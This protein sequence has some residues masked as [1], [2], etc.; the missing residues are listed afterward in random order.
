MALRQNNRSAKKYLKKISDISDIF[1]LFLWYTFF[2]GSFLVAVEQTDRQTD[3]KFLG[4][5]ILQK[6]ITSFFLYFS[7]KVGL[8]WTMFYIA[9][10]RPYTPLHRHYIALH[11][12]YT[13]LKR[14]YTQLARRGGQ[15]GDE[16][17]VLRYWQNLGSEHFRNWK[18]SNKHN[19]SL[20]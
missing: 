14:P 18:K 5:E 11:S 3:S 9:L 10:H 12:H 8:T 19:C 4:L 6:C 20:L 7:W 13:A 16:C 1:T 15:S 17:F 2:F